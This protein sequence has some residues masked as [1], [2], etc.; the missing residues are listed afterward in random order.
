MHITAILGHETIALD[1]IEQAESLM[2][3]ISKAKI[4]N[5]SFDQDGSQVECLSEKTINLEIKLSNNPKRR[6]DSEAFKAID[7]K[8][9]ADYEKRKNDTPELFRPAGNLNTA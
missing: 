4:I 8:R 1:S 3:I 2:A 6:I 7:E 5:V 9:M